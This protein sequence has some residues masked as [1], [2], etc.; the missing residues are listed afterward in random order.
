MSD[1]YT[2]N[3]EI[4]PSDILMPGGSASEATIRIKHNS[5]T[6]EKVA[7]RLRP[8]FE[9]ADP[10]LEWRVVVEDVK[11]HAFLFT[12]AEPKEEGIERTVAPHMKSEYVLRVFSPRGA[13]I[14]DRMT[15][16]LRAWFSKNPAVSAETRITVTVRQSVVAVKTT[17]GQEIPVAVS[18]G[19]KA[20]VRGFE[21]DIFSILVPHDIKGYVFV[22]TVHP[23]KVLSIIRGMRAA[24]GMVHGNMQVEEVEKYLTP[25]S[26]ITR[27]SVGDEVELIEGPF[28]G[29]RAKVIQVDEAKEEVTVELYEA[30]VPIPLTV[31]VDTVKLREKEGK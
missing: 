9:V 13:R 8:E 18:I 11:E 31:K 16:T 10:S 2:I 25:V 7:L 20:K 19:E 15:L 5:T 21:D 24:K 26:E 22:E 29:E 1:I 23:D 28:K 27:I 14:G 6:K 30:M 4:E 3:L 17:I 12:P